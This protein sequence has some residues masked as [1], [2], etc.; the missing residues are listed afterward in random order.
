LFLVVSSDVQSTN[1]NLYEI[2]FFGLSIMKPEEWYKLNSEELRA[3]FQ[4]VVVPTLSNGNELVEQSLKTTTQDIVFL[5]GLLKYPPNT[6]NAQSNPNIIG[7][8]EKIPDGMRTQNT[9]V[10]S[11]NSS[12]S[13]HQVIFNGR[14]FMMKE[15]ISGN[16][17][18]V[19]YTANKENGYHFVFTL[20][21]TDDINKYELMNITNTLKL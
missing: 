8:A 1:D 7:L 15:T 3:M 16:T 20:S 6:E 4:N 13:C 18:Q 21:Y 9:C 5:F 11:D 14:V 12:G 10:I 19:Q 2:S 17:K